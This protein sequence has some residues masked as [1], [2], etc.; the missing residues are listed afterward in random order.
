ML[1]PLPSWSDIKEIPWK[2]VTEALR[3]LAQNKPLNVIIIGGLLLVSIA[4][5][6]WYWNRSSYYEAIINNTLR[7]DLVPT[8]QNFKGLEAFLISN[9]TFDEYTKT[10]APDKENFTKMLGTASFGA[11]FFRQWNNIQT[12]LDNFNKQSQIVAPQPD[13]NLQTKKVQRDG[14]ESL[15]EI[16][17]QSAEDN[18]QLKIAQGD[19]DGLILTD[20]KTPGFLFLPVY[21]LRPAFSQKEIHSLGVTVPS[22]EDKQ[23]VF[24]VPSDEDR[25][26]V[27][28][29]INNAI[30]DDT[31]LRRD[32]SLTNALAK[33]LNEL[34]KS[35]VIEVEQGVDQFVSKPAQVYIITKNGVNRIFNRHVEGNNIELYYGNQFPATTFFPSRPYFWP[36]FQRSKVGEDLKLNSNRLG[37]YF[38]ITGP[39]MDLA[40]NGFV[41]TL[42]RGIQIGEMTQAV[43]C[44][45]LVLAPQKSVNDALID[46]THTF[47]GTYA[48]VSCDM[49]QGKCA[50]DTNHQDENAKVS[51]ATKKNL[52]DSIQRYIDQ[53]AQHE[54]SILGGNIQVINTNKKMD[55]IQISLPTGADYTGDVRIVRL[56]LLDLNLIEYE[57]NTN[58]IAVM[59]CF[60]FGAMLLMLTFWL[61]STVRVKEEYED[62]F[63]RVAKVMYN[64]KTPYVRLDAEDRISEC[65]LS[66]CEKLGYEPD[67]ASITELKKFKFIDLIAD[68]N[69]IAIYNNVQESRVKDLDVKP[70]YLKLNKLGGDIIAVKIIS[71][72]VPSYEVGKI[73]E[74]F[75][76]LLD[77]KDTNSTR[78]QPQM[79]PQ[80]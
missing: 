48:Y 74:T 3:R 69:S 58:L 2:S 75:G 21:I 56:L 78:H 11:D 61:A 36:V 47:N 41:M 51:E 73:P 65:S 33:T 25:Q 59:A 40:G 76:I 72:A 30:K 22:D 60:T 16:A 77:D 12:D 4:L 46:L 43:I 80:D 10:D 32:V 57:R 54:S 14:H 19:N 6:W 71:A 17:R 9:L 27:L 15:E 1:I 13:E 62:A 24:T 20:G 63:K 68:E 37:D 53:R 79:P 26:K 45:D 5:G 28:Q 66:F 67:D 55:N 7:A 31:N 44:I 29:K 39:Y 18:V 49:I 8:P 42:S 35:P 64:S 70:Y 38:H 52:I 23:K 34:T 50:P